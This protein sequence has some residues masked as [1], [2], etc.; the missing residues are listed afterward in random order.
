MFQSAAV[1]NQPLAAWN[2]AKVGWYRLTIPIPVLKA[3]ALSALETIINIID[4]Y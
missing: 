4:R 3:Q 2:T 1:F